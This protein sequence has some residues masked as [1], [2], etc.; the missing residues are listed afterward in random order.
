MAGTGQRFTT[1]TEAGDGR[2]VPWLAARGPLAYTVEE[3]PDRDYFFQYGWILPGVL[4][5]RVNPR[6]HCYFGAYS[7]DDAVDIF[8]FWNAARARA[9]EQVFVR[10]GS[11]GNGQVSAPLAAYHW[12][13]WRL[14]PSFMLIQHGSYLCIDVGDQPAL[15]SGVAHLYRGIQKSDV[16]V[17]PSAHRAPDAWWR[18]YLAV[19]AEVLS[20]SMTSFNSVHDRVKRTETTHIRDGSWLTDDIARRHGLAIDAEAGGVWTAAHQSFSLRRSLAENKFGPNFV[21]CA[22]PVENL[23]LTTFFAGEDEVRVVDPRLVEVVDAIGCR[24]DDGGS[25]HQI[26]S[27]SWRMA[28]AGR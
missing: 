1:S 4:N 9:V 22:T 5:P 24:V 27:R 15:A 25:R 8:R 20:D 28:S 6:H 17:T 18:N 7:K 13:A 21:V 26:D 12:N 3:P 16:F 2:L 11:L 23:R 14:R 19:Q 10:D